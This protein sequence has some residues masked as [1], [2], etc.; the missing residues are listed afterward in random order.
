[1]PIFLLKHLETNCL[2]SLPFKCS[3]GSF[4]FS[5]AKCFSTL[6][7]H[8]VTLGS[9]RRRTNAAFVQVPRRAAGAQLTDTTL[10]LSY[11]TKSPSLA[12][13]TTAFITETKTPP[14]AT[15]MSRKGTCQKCSA[16]KIQSVQVLLRQLG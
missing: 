16:R 10:L 9:R 7:G 13:T 12:R 1:M 6:A 2:C 3:T 11:Y 14:R 8:R 4:F 15:R 5:A